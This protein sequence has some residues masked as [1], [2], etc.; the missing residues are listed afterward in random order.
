[1]SNPI[2]FF[3][4][5]IVIDLILKSVRDKKKISQ[6]KMDREGS[7][8]NK[9]ELNKE[10]QIQKSGSIREVMS[11]LR[12]EVE[13]ERQK[14][15]ERRQGTVKRSEKVI[16]KTEEE[17]IKEKAYEDNKYWEEKRSLENK[18]KTQEK[19]KQEEL[20]SERNIR[21]DILRGIIFSEVLSP[22]KAIENKRNR[23]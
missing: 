11:T 13:K 19:N 7:F 6:K 12:E 22:P 1:M 9:E 10:K 21:E 17:I 8:E 16:V 5:I 15:L 20:S 2:L 3:I 4:F 23:V 18:K 14:D